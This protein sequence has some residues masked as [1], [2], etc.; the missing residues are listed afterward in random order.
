MGI[1]LV[2]GTAA[3][4]LAPRQAQAAS[5]PALT[6]GVPTVADAVHTYGEPDIN[7]DASGRVFVS[8]P[9]GTGTQRSMWSGSSDSQAYR[10]VNQ[11]AAVGPGP[12]FGINDP[13]GGG[14]TEIVFDNGTA[15]GHANQG[16]YFSDLFALLCFRVE[17][18]HD[19]GATNAQN[20]VPGTAGCSSQQPTADRQWQTVF[21][22]P[23]GVVSTS[24]VTT[25]P[26]IYLTYNAGGAAWNKS[27]DGVNFTPA[28]SATPQTPNL[29]F[30]NDG[31]PAIDQ[32]TGKVFE[33]AGG[34]A[35]TIQMNI[36]TPNDAAGDLT[37]LDD[38][39]GPGLITIANG[40][41]G[42][43][44]AHFPVLTMDKA[45]N[46]Y[47]S[48]NISSGS[49]NQDQVFVAAAPADDTRSGHACT[50]C[51]TNWTTPVQV[52]DGLASTGDAVNSF[53]WSASGGDH[54]I[55][56]VAWYGSNKT[57][58][59]NT[60]NC[61]ADLHSA[62]C[63]VWSLFMNQVKFA[64]DAT[65]VIT[66]PPVAATPTPI[67]AAPH[68]MHYGDI[69]GAGTG[70]IL[71]QGNRNLADFFMVRTDAQGAAEIVYDDTS[72]G[73][74][75][76]GAP[77]SNQ[78]AD[79]A[80]APVVTVIR[81]D[82]G[83]GVFGTP[84]TEAPS[85][86]A[87]PTSHVS[88]VANNALYSTASGAIAGTNVPAMDVLDSGMSLS[89][90]TLTVTMKVADLTPPAA[91]TASTA[92]GAP[93]YVTR[94]VMATPGDPQHPYTIFYAGMAGDATTQ[95]FYAGPAQSSDLCSVS[96]CFPHV[97]LYPESASSTPAVA[98][99]VNG[100]GEAGSVSC[101]T[102]PSAANPCTITITVNTAHIGNP[103]TSSLLE[104]VGAYSFAVSH[105]QA[106]QT[107]A[108]SQADSVPLMI[109]GV[110]CF[111]FQ[112]SPANN[113]AET[114]WTAALVLVGLTGVVVAA[115]RRRRRSGRGPVPAS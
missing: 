7:M 70:C 80:G 114:P 63:E 47:A 33:A 15:A 5:P 22:P 84:V 82:S 21:D 30:G 74:L 66:G 9:T 39:G 88:G 71:Q 110:C 97:T 78:T 35:G 101:P 108:Q 87:T 48:W 105:P 89:G 49:P 56:D 25:K 53:S 100:S 1:L 27:P 95:T 8:G 26:L 91:T 32:V 24:P 115:A 107:L 99:V 83:I 92:G 36:G 98:P 50:S 112:P 6:F 62:G 17:A 38:V 44:N 76:A 59:P 43:P 3:A 77:P 93:E 29:H 69:C 13:P 104:E 23:A 51:W 41:L 73:L 19:G 2:A 45:R 72:N 86:N 31:Y 10:L 109:D 81:Q 40:L 52:S 111:N 16:M 60:N 90:T 113:V 58:D 55:A 42:T 54:G 79:H 65:G 106:V 96:A 103:T 57:D 28:D 64:T 18:S 85:T 20:S 67:L 75:T 61:G 4:S 14:D 11:N 34:A 94:W 46:L 102:T 12:V 68:P 37:F